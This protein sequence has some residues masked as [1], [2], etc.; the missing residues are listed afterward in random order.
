MKG[1]FLNPFFSNKP[2]AIFPFFRFG[3]IGGLAH[4]AKVFFASFWSPNRILKT[5]P[6]KLLKKQGCSKYLLGSLAHIVLG[7]IEEYPIE[8]IINF[9]I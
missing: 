7:I 5:A 1:R 2:Q 4:S 8:I 3:A 9:Q 6:E